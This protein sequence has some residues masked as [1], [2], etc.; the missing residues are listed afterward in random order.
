MLCRYSTPLQDIYKIGGIGMVPVGRVETGVVRAGMQVVFA[1]CGVTTEVKSV[2]V[3]V[4][5]RPLP[6]ITS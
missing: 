4:T 2:Q 5:T 1:P 6:L 3:L